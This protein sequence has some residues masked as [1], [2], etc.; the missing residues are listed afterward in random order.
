[1]RSL[2]QLDYQ[3]DTKYSIRRTGVVYGWVLNAKN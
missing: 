2:T 3:W 1:M